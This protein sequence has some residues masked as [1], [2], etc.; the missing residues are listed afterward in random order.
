VSW[1]QLPG[2]SHASACH[3]ETLPDGSLY[4]AHVPAGPF[5]LELQHRDWPRTRHLVPEGVSE[6]RVRLTPGLTLHGTVKDGRGRPLEGG[7]VHAVQDGEW[8]FARIHPDGTY[9]LRVPPGR[10][11]L[12]VLNREGRT[13]AYEGAEGQSVRVDLVV[14][15]VY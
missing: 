15:G 12:Q 7:D 2:S 6:A 14:P 9:T 8:H 13:A 1:P 3:G 11:T 4:L 5:L 10:G